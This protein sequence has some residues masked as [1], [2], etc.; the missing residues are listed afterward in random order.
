[1][2]Q[3]GATSTTVI[4]SFGEWKGQMVAIRH[5]V[6]PCDEHDLRVMHHFGPQERE[7]DPLIHYCP[8]G[9]LH[10][11]NCFGVA[12]EPEPHECRKWGEA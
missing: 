5:G 1:M 3:T 8:T 11:R 7:S 10:C 4:V 9:F 2:I 6:R 12:D